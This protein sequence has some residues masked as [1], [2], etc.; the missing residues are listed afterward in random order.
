M[1]TIN[2]TYFRRNMSSVLDECEGCGKSSEPVLITTTKKG[3][4]DKQ[5]MILITEAQY[6]MMIDGINKGK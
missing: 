2:S 5:R 1:K 4:K 6:I 3:R